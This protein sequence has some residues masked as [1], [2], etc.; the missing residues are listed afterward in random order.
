MFSEPCA[1]SARCTS[2]QSK[3]VTVSR[4][5]YGA[6]WEAEPNPTP[7][8]QVRCSRDES[9]ARYIPWRCELSNCHH[10][11]RQQQ[12]LYDCTTVVCLDMVIW[13]IGP[14]RAVAGDQ[15][16]RSLIRRAV[17]AAKRQVREPA[18]G[19]VLGGLGHQLWFRTARSE[20]REPPSCVSHG[21]LGCWAAT[22][23]PGV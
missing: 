21:V 23:A 12:L 10:Q 9:W 17:V 5:V 16:Y 15:R 22:G 4:C 14:A 13:W 8:M 18:S 19:C 20:A 1:T 6:S 11:I 3:A 7:A 2:M